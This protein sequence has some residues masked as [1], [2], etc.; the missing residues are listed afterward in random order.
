MKL[1]GLINNK[2]N[3]YIYILLILR[4]ISFESHRVG[5]HDNHKEYP[6]IGMF[7]FIGNEKENDKYLHEYTNYTPTSGRMK[8]SD[9]SHTY[10]LNK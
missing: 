10:T 9:V 7:I 4:N 3:I 8:T 5:I 2:I 1:F 6:P